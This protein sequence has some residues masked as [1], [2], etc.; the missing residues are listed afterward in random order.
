MKKYGF[1]LVE[2]LA[3]IVILAII[4]LIAV[5]IILNII[6]D[7]KKQ[8]DERSI[9]LYGDA[10]KNAVADYSL[11][12]PTDEEVTFEDIE[13]DY[14]EYEGSKVECSTH[15]IYSD[16]NIWLNGC[17]VNGSPV[18]YEYGEKRIMPGTYYGWWLEE[19]NLTVGGQLPNEL[20]KTPPTGKDVYLKLDTDGSTVSAAYACF[21]RGRTEYCLKG[22]DTNAY[23]E[24]EETI[25]KAFAG[26]S[27]SCSCS[28]EGADCIYYCVGS[29]DVEAYSDGNVNAFDGSRGCGVNG[30]FYCY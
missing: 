25:K 3:V 10:I 26:S 15:E 18:E 22:Y 30:T 21:K 24:N 1:T 8:S 2:L 27:S 29:L 20:S 17:T 19:E 14:I 28:Y 6:G 11:K 23:K 9:E 4:A 5:P 12:N 7:T 13:E 16:G